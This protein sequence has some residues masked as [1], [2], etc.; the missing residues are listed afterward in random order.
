MTVRIKIIGL[1]GIMVVAYAM[2]APKMPAQS[3]PYQPS[4]QTHFRSDLG[5]TAGHFPKD[6]TSMDDKIGHSTYVYQSDQLKIEK[7]AEHSYR[8]ISYMNTDDFG[9]VSCNGMVVIDAG[10]AI[11]FDTPVSEKAAQ[12]LIEWIRNERESEIKAIIPTHFHYDCLATL[13]IFHTQGI[14]S[15]AY[16][17]TIEL[18]RS[19]GLP[20]PQ[21]GFDGR[22]DL[23]LSQNMVRVEFFGAGHTMDNVIGYY[24]PDR[25]L[26]G[27]C[28]IKSLQAGNGNLEDADVE[29]W[30]ATMEKIQQ[31]F[32]E[33]AIII[34][35]HGKAGDLE[36]LEYT[37]EMFSSKN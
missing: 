30:P 23:P 34:P 36:L 15:Y 11:I 32:S 27:G 29:K 31:T 17:K 18:A 16:T 9:K 13:D 33:A 2:V 26:F 35:G 14:P 1:A 19:S 4:P 8:H 24:A 28:L 6:G 25:S 3:A 20:V 5:N 22:I 10:Q 12:E 21:N 37:K 7:L